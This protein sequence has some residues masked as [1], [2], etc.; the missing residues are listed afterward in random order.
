LIYEIE[1]R[2][3]NIELFIGNPSEKYDIKR[4]GVFFL[5]EGCIPLRVSARLEPSRGYF[6]KNIYLQ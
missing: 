5:L 4:G 3:E 1:G 2:N 6:I